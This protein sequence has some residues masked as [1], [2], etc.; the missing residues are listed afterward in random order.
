MTSPLTLFRV[1]GIPVGLHWS[2]LVVFGLLTMSLGRGYLPEEYPELGPL[3]TWAIAAL[4]A[5]LLF[6]SVLLHE[7]GHAWAAQRDGVPVRGITLFIFGGVAQLASDA[8]TPGA[9]FRIAIAGPIVSL[10]LAAAFAAIWWLDSGVQVLAA[11]SE[12]L[13]RINLSLALFNMVPGFPLDGGRV[14]RSAI[15]A[16]TGDPHRSTQAASVVGQ[17]AAFTFV[18]VGIALAVSGHVLNGMWLGFIGWFLQ[19]AAAA[20]YASATIEQQVRGVR[21]G[22]VMDLEAPTVPAWETLDAMVHQR[23][24]PTGRRWFLVVDAHRLAG[25]VTLEDVISVPQ[26]DWP[27]TRVSAVMRPADRMVRVSRDTELS[28]ALRAM[29][30]GEVAHVPVMDGERVS[31]VL[32]RERVLRHLRLRAELRMPPRPEAA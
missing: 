29:D 17:L 16:W 25:L 31:G 2:L 15:W 8:R 24:V 12:W 10:A 32:T 4:T 23:I 18:G 13:V 3:A 6:V 28:T 5:G 20:S 22:Q 1:R 9:E 26:A 27:T 30:D 11:P 14:L 19:N 21:A 7:L